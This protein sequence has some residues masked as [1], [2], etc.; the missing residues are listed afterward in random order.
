MS[1][2]FPINYESQNNIGIK[3]YYQDRTS[4]IKLET[5]ICLK[6]MLQQNDE[7]TIFDLDAIDYINNGVHVENSTFAQSLSID[8]I[9][10]SISHP[11]SFCISSNFM[12]IVYPTTSLGQSFSDDTGT[13]TFNTIVNTISTTVKLLPNNSP[14]F[15][16]DLKIT[17]T[18]PNIS[19]DSTNDTWKAFFDSSN[20]NFLLQKAV[21]SG[22]NN[23]TTK[24][25]LT[26]S[27]DITFNNTYALGKDQLSYYTESPLT[28][29][30]VIH[31]IDDANKVTENKI[32]IVVNTNKLNSDSFGSYKIHQP[33]STVAINYSN[34]TIG[35]NY[36]IGQDYNSTPT[37][38]LDSIDTL[39]EFNRIF[40]DTSEN[41]SLEILLTKVDNNSGLNF[42][43]ISH[44]DYFT[45][46]N[47]PMINNS[48]F[49]EKI[50]LT[51]KSINMEF[52]QDEMTITP[53]A[54]VSEITTAYTANNAFVLT[55]N[56]EKLDSISYNK[57]GE[58]MLE[59]LS[60]EN[61][62]SI[63]AGVG[64]LNGISALYPRIEVD[65][66]NIDSEKRNTKNI[67][68]MI[69]NII[70]PTIT[71]EYGST[72]YSNET[73]LFT[74]N[75]ATNGANITLVAN[76]S[77][78]IDEIVLIKVLPQIKL[79]SQTNVNYNNLYILND[80]ETKADELTNEQVDIQISGDI[81][82]LKAY[83]DLRFALFPKT[84]TD[85][86]ISY[87]GDS[88][89]NI[90]T[91]NYNLTLLD[92]SNPNSIPIP[93]PNGWCI[94][95]SDDIGYLSSDLNI[96]KNTRNIFPSPN[97]YEYLYNNKNSSFSMNIVYK[98]NNYNSDQIDIT[99]NTY[100]R[101]LTEYDDAIP[102][103][104][105]PSQITGDIDLKNINNTV[106]SSKYKKTINVF[107]KSLKKYDQVELTT[108][109]T[110]N[111]L[112]NLNLAGFKNIQVM[113]PL[114]YATKTTYFYYLQSITS[115]ANV[116][117][118]SD[119]NSK[120]S[121]TNDS[122]NV[123]YTTF[124]NATIGSTTY[125]SPKTVVNLNSDK[126]KKIETILTINNDSITPLNGQI[127]YRNK[128]D[129]N[130]YSDWSKISYIIKNI[131]P[132]FVT[133][134]LNIETGGYNI[135]I[136]LQPNYYENNSG[137]KINFISFDK[138]KYFVPI[139][140]DNTTTSSVVTCYKYKIASIPTLFETNFD[141]K[142]FITNDLIT[143]ALTQNLSVKVTY[144]NPDATE[145]NQTYTATMEIKNEVGDTIATITTDKAGFT[146]PIILAK[147][148]QNLFSVITE[149]DTTI[150]PPIYI[151]GDNDI[152]D[153]TSGDI[154]LSNGIKVSY[155][156]IKQFNNVE[157]SLK[158]D[159]IVVNMIG[160]IGTNLP[161]PITSLTYSNGFSEEMSIPYYRGYKT[162]NQSITKQYN[163]KI[164]RKDL[165]SYIINVDTDAKFTSG[166]FEN[167][168]VDAQ[169]TISFSDNI[170]SIGTTVI[171]LFSRLPNSSLTTNKLIMPIIISS[172]EVKITR[173]SYSTGVE[174]K[175]IETKLLQDCELYTFVNGDKLRALNLRASGTILNNSKVDDYYLV[176]HGRANISIYHNDSDIGNPAEADWGTKISEISFTN[177]K[178]GFIINETGIDI[179]GFLTVTASDDTK[180]DSISFIVIA[181]P[182]ICATQL[183]IDG[184]KNLPFDKNNTSEY[185]ATKLVTRYFPIVSSKIA[186]YKPFESISN[187]NINN[188]R[189]T[190][191]DKEFSD[192]NNSSKNNTD[193]VF[194]ISGSEITMQEID[195]NG[196]PTKSG[197]DNNGI[198]FQG[199][200]SDLLNIKITD[201][202]YNYIKLDSNINNELKLSY[203]QQNND[204]FNTVFN[205]S[206]IMPEYNIKMSVSGFFIKDNTLSPYR[207]VSSIIKGIKTNIYDMIKRE[208]DIV[209]LKYECLNIDFTNIPSNKSINQIKFNPKKVYKSIVTMPVA[210]FGEKYLQKFN[211]IVS[212][213]MTTDSSGNIVWTEIVSPTIL[214]D[215]F[216]LTITAAT[217][218]GLLS[219]IEI[220]YAT[221]DIPVNFTVFK[222]PNA[223]E[224]L[225]TDGRPKFIIT[226]FGQILSPFINTNVITL[227]DKIQSS[228][229]LI[230]TN[231]TVFNT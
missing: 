179:N 52:T 117:T 143:S 141:P 185:D 178:K 129:L 94:G 142:Y 131:E 35:Q 4:T 34:T 60:K 165:I 46:N 201:K 118:F 79:K 199:F 100:P 188:V 219:I 210:K 3:K 27:E 72:V 83:D 91:F 218:D 212:S 191:I 120:I 41:N 78:T 162:D 21:N 183:D 89:N 194:V 213:N 106:I 203:T 37:I 174:V 181:K 45:I 197:P 160:P 38:L 227:F 31:N 148:N 170:G 50:V 121:V 111:I 145:G 65:Y 164:N 155:K 56:G 140:L 209:L 157:F 107:E 29:K 22:L 25:L 136:S 15:D 75:A 74:N 204:L 81:T 189:F 220:L 211:D 88:D 71:G 177:A 230:G 127:E 18:N 175:V 182:Q 66:D 92:S 153:K 166:P 126:N 132:Y 104:D 225:G 149:Y 180:T 90:K 228:V 109:S 98:I 223:M 195:I 167:I 24:S 96:F 40:N 99:Y 176:T 54:L 217:D 76:I 59:I 133:E 116:F 114:I 58:I 49:M 202:F 193:V 12:E 1:T 32:S 8:D 9:N 139:N 67:K 28:T 184:A 163:Y 169:N 23:Q 42:S 33:I 173:T 82:T 11:T 105:N 69:K 84:I 73:L 47:A 85:L 152:R 147:C 2:T 48:S 36:S 20:P 151:S 62:T 207:L 206:A 115:I 53:N 214:L 7:N 30:L 186:D 187:L 137:E 77:S 16:S 57:D 70:N 19:F 44:K 95:Y 64:V 108:I 158:P 198:I 221:S 161:Q 63:T 156:S 128:I 113:T 102:K 39:D 222:L 123:S 124:S 216:S 130:T 68:Y 146:A 122:T 97:D 51:K 134:P 119:D 138:A 86:N 6:H 55:K 43:D 103:P 87:D 231:A 205:D 110:Y 80:D 26:I 5:D 112:F 125:I 229:D 192:Y 159:N 215:K 190:S 144:S 172:D 14:I 226:A 13:N 10:C 224:I 93:N 101:P 208:N 135:I 61:R 154:Y 196:S 17:V 168:F 200:T 150:S 171:S